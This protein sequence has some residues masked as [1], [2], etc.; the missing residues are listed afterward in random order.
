MS[1]QF[2][3]VSFRSV[4]VFEPG[5]I[6]KIKSKSYGNPEV[7]K[8][9]SNAQGKVSSIRWALDKKTK[10][11]R[12]SQLVSD[13][14]ASADFLA[15]DLELIEPARNFSLLCSKKE[16]ALALQKLVDLNP[17]YQQIKL[18]EDKVDFSFKNKAKAFLS[19]VSVDLISEDEAIRGSLNIR[20]LKKLGL[21]KKK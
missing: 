15:S 9:F 19:T 6:V 1:N 21:L 7:A 12:V 10:L 20:N 4:G 16:D 18:V 5:D 3:V 17:F 14:P 8:S 13:W 11:V 2:F